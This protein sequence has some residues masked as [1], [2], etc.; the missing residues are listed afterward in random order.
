MAVG[1]E[2]DLWRRSKMGGRPADARM[3]SQSGFDQSGPAR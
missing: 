1:A 2:L 3:A